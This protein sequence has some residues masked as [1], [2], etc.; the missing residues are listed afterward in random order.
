MQNLMYFFGAPVS[1]E[2]LARLLAED[3]AIV[4]VFRGRQEFGP[5]V[6]PHAHTPHRHRGQSGGKL[7]MQTRDHAFI[8]YRHRNWQ[9]RHLNQL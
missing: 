7:R 2:S 9:A 6:G 3:H 8:A 4:A 5:G 1:P